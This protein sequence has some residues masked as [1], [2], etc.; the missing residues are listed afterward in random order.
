M[1]FKKRYDEK[2][3]KEALSL[4]AILSKQIKLGKYKVENAGFWTSGLD[5]KMQFKFEIVN[6]D[7]K[8]S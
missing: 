7:E 3:K 6:T 4:L 1:S 5:G 2:K 8:E